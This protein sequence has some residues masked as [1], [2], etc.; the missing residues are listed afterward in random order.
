MAKIIKVTFKDTGK[1][2]LFRKYVDIF[3]K[4]TTDEIGG[5]LGSV[6]N[7]SA[8]LGG[9]YENKKVLIEKL[10]YSSEMDAEIEKAE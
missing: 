5:V 1:T 10:P 6:W 9:R 4:F 2:Y 3:K 8:L 7:S